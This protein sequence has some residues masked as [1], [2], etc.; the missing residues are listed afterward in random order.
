MVSHPILSV[1]M[2]SSP[3]KVIKVF[4]VN[5][6]NIDLLHQSSLSSNLTSYYTELVYQQDSNFNP[7]L[8][9]LPHKMF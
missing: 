1:Y 8:W 4:T 7:S 2:L 9:V 3:Q 6:L 5:P